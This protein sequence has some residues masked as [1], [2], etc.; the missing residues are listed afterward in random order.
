M[1]WFI[2]SGWAK[3]LIYALCG[4]ALFVLGTLDAKYI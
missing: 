1:T 3:V 4:L 2:Y